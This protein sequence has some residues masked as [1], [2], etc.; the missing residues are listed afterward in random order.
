M[1]LP[2]L[3]FSNLSVHRVRAA[4]TI[5]AIALSVSL[6]V[7]VTTG[8]NSSIAAASK[9]LGVY[10]GTADLQITRSKGDP[11][12]TFPE[13]LADDLRKDRRV[14]LVLTRYGT[15]SLLLDDKGQKVKGPAIDVIGLRRPQ[16][17]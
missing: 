15:G 4:L 14:K 7:A 8:Y 6:V 1:V 10:M 17:T 9:F 16:D 12:G 13:S 3:V 11:H 5:S 2:K